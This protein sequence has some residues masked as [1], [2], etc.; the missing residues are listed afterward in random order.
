MPKVRKRERERERESGWERG[1]KRREIC[2]KEREK[3]EGDKMETNID[4]ERFYKVYQKFRLIHGKS[5]E[6]II[7]G[8]LLAT[9]WSEQYFFEAAGAVAKLAGALNQTLK[10]SWACPN[11]WYTQ[12]ER[13]K[14][15]R[16]C[17]YLCVWERMRVCVCSRER[18]M[19]LLSLSWSAHKVSTH[20][21]LPQNE[22]EELLCQILSSLY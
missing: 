10:S 12:Y 2:I 8:S 22:V 14:E 1:R 7:C 15:G 16:E 11:P 20:P 17:V 13:E 9:F 18:K 4:E 6:K 5:S 19:W 21:C 3:G